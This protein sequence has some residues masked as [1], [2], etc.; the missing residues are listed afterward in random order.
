MSERSERIH[1][2]S[3]PWIMRALASVKLDRSFA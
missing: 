3:D 1:E 2:H